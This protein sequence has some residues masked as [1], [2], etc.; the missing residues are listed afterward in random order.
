MALAL[1]V[2]LLLLTL[3]VPLPFA[4]ITRGGQVIVQSVAF[5]ALALCCFDASRLIRRTIVPALAIAGVGL[6]GLLQAARWPAGWVERVSPRHAE[7]YADAAT[8]AGAKLDPALSL[9]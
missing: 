8:L 6:I 9:A 5:L 1:A 4:S 7:L 3:W 2:V